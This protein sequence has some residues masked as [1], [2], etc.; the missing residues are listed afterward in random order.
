MNFHDFIS[1]IDVVSIND[2]LRIAAI[3]RPYLT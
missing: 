3:Q 2:E 1:C